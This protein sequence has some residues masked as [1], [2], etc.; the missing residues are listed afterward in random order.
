[1]FIILAGKDCIKVLIISIMIS[2][3]K[4]SCVFE[5]YAYADQDSQSSVGYGMVLHFLFCLGSYLYL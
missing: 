5:F 4:T 1:M 2:E 3:K